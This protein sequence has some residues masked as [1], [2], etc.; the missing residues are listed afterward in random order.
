[1]LSHGEKLKNKLIIF[2]FIIVFIYA[3]IV[4]IGYTQ[5][6]STDSIIEESGSTAKYQKQEKKKEVT[7]Y[8][9]KTGKNTI[10]GVVAI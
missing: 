3:A 1:M 5:E 4:L 2:G 8:I 9:T 6:D 10:R 7:V